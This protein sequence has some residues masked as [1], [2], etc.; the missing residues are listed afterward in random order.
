MAQR[1]ILGDLDILGRAMNDGGFTVESLPVGVDIALHFL[2][3]KARPPFPESITLPNGTC[4]FLVA[5]LVTQA[6]LDYSRE[7]GPDGLQDRLSV[8]GV[9]QMSSFDRKSVV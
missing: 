2:V 9:G 6:E 8:A 7:H 1:E 5:M 3:T 4:Q